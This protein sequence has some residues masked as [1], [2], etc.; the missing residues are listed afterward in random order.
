MCVCVESLCVNAM[1]TPPPFFLSPPTLMFTPPKQEVTP[2][3]HNPN[4]HIIMPLLLLSTQPTNQPVIF[5]I[6]HNWKEK[7]KKRSKLMGR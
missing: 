2:Y 3:N 4:K 6:N 7:K 1:C 5:S